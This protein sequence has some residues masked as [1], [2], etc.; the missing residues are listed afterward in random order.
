MVTSHRG[1]FRAGYLIGHSV[2][3]L[4]CQLLYFGKLLHRQPWSIWT[5]SGC[6]KLLCGCG[7]K[8]LRH[9]T[10][11]YIN[12]EAL[13]KLH[14]AQSIK[15]SCLGIL[16]AD[17]IFMLC[18]VLLAIFL[19]IDWCV[20]TCGPMVSHNREANTRPGLEISILRGMDSSFYEL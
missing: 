19:A 7:L 15:S 12:N 2:I 4:L 16:I 17:N 20:A 18:E 5:C 13:K 1:W 9:G 11:R 3:S 8:F 14:T 10:S 6:L